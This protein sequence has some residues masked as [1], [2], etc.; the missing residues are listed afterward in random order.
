MDECPQHEGQKPQRKGQ[1]AK[2]DG[3]QVARYWCPRDGGHSFSEPVPG[4]GPAPAPEPKGR[5]RT[6]K[7]ATAT[8]RCPKPHHA[9]AKVTKFGTYET[10]A[11]RWQRYLCNRPNGQGHTFALLTDANGSTLL[12]LTTPPT[13]PDHPNSHVVRRGKHRRSQKQV[14][15]KSIPS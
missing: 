11:G 12:S 13:C 8:V 10:D 5:V 9:D 15:S 7:T 3:T 4:T 6:R 2:K 14:K 1:R